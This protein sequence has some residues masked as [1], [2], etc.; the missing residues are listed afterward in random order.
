MR[1]SKLTELLMRSNLI[2]IKY[3]S[4]NDLVLFL[5]WVI[6]LTFILGYIYHIFIEIDYKRLVDDMLF[7]IKIQDIMIKPNALT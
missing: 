1:K 2:R 7:Y 5:V 4:K 3:I 6:D